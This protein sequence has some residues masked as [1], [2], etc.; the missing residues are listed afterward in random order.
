[1]E[2]KAVVKSERKTAIQ[3]LADRLH[4]SQ[5]TMQKTLQATAF[6]ECKTTEEFVSAVIVANT[7][8]LN[9]LLKEIYAFPSRGG[10]IP[11]VSVDG[12]ISLVN[13]NRKFDGVELIDNL[14]EGG[15]LISVTAKFYLKD[16]EHAVVITEHM[17]ECKRDTDT[18]KKYPHRMLRHKAYIQGARVAFGLS[19][20]YDE[21]EA[22]R[23]VEAEYVNFNPKADV[24]MPEALPEKGAEVK[25]DYAGMLKNFEAAKKIHGEDLYYAVLKTH[26]LKHANEIRS[27]D[28][29]KQIISEIIELSA[30]AEK[31]SA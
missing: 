25:V 28:L 12:W 15:E 13:R 26:G 29:G 31:E 8:G 27:L 5:E 4:V 9:P 21:D 17:A 23:I 2:T 6:K 10:V 11:I 19:G 18:W 16:T 3:L 30:T 1:M 22:Q 14:D 24:K 7:Y 20:I